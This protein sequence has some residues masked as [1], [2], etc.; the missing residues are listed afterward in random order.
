M[1]NAE[2][3]TNFLKFNKKAREIRAKR[4]GY[5]SAAAYIAF[6]SGGG[7]VAP[8]A[9]VVEPIVATPKK[10]KKVKAVLSGVPTIHI[11]DIAD[12]SGSMAGGKDRA[13]VTGINKGLAELRTNKDGFDSQVYIE[14]VAVHPD[15]AHDIRERTVGMT[16]LWDAIGMTVQALELKVAIGDKVLVNIYTDGEENSS[17]KFNSSAIRELI[18]KYSLQGWTFTFIGTEHDVA[19]VIKRVN[20]KKSNT[21]TYDGTAEGLS[22]GMS[23]NSISRSNFVAKAKAGEDTSFGYFSKDIID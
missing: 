20:I 23:T 10:S 21:L 4:L 16:A 12:K 1:T 11:V 17:R 22:R 9:P 6:L 8:A 15:K 13:T 2:L 3:R 7:F 14:Q 18:D 5:Q 19:E